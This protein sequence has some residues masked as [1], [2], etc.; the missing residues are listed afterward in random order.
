MFNEKE[1]LEYFKRLPAYNAYKDK[2]DEEVIS[3]LFDA[4]EDIHSLYPDVKISNRMIAKQM[5]F[6]DEAEKSGFGISQ[7]H[8]LSSRKINDASITFSGSYNMYD[9]YVWQIIQSQMGEGK[10]KA[11]FG[12][13]V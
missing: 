7:R 8:G 10:L 4:Y 3:K 12:R 9:P 2:T 13:L 11:G 5:L 6:K 1:V